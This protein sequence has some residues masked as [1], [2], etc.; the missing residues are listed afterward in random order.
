ML[1]NSNLNSIIKN[2][3]ERWEAVKIMT[4]EK[5]PRAFDIHFYRSLVNL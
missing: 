1:Y 2:N 3:K 4:L 5:W